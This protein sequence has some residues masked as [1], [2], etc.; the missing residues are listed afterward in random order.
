M[1]AKEQTKPENI[2]E[3]DEQDLVLPD[4]ID[5]QA[6]QDSMREQVERVQEIVLAFSK[7]EPETWRKALENAVIS[8]IEAIDPDKLPAALLD[9][10]SIRTLAEQ[11][12]NGDKESAKKT[13][14]HMRAGTFR[15]LVH[16]SPLKS[17]QKSL[18]YYSI[19]NDNVNQQLIVS[20]P[21]IKEINGQVKHLWTV[22]K[23]SGSTP[24]PVLACLTYRGEEKLKKTDKRITAFDEGVI[25]AIGTIAHT[26][27]TAGEHFPLMFT[28][29]DI[30]RTRNGITDTRR[31]PSKK[32]IDRI[33]NSIDKMRFVDLFL[34]RSEEIKQFNLTQA[35]G[36][37]IDTHIIKGNYISGTWK[38]IGSKNGRMVSV[39]KLNEMPQMFAYNASLGH[40]IFVP[41]GL[42]KLSE[43]NLTPYTEEIRDYLIKEIER[44]YTNTRDNKSFLF[45]TIHTATDWPTPAERIDKSKY[46]D[47]KTYQSKLRTEEAADRKKVESILSELTE[48]K[49][50]S[51]FEVHKKSNSYSVEITPRKQ[52]YKNMRSSTLIDPK[53]LDLTPKNPKKKPAQ[54]PVAKPTKNP[55]QNPQKPVANGRAKNTKKVHK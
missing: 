41:F 53:M 23:G 35:D 21:T 51:G 31:T 43:K 49:Y 36:S 22:P 44:I 2:E 52:L 15:K 16:A 32:Q 55:L 45:S 13:V 24:A 50:I 40:V 34:D 38:I 17:W 48:K 28:A 10:K 9:N 14:Y 29:E 25:N 26:Q 11:I 5:I 39:F 54:K 47:E 27:L 18:T 37:P 3:L 30:W 6:I 19:M 33:R 7:V 12:R 20:D 42:L 46:K 1:T 8:F 4:D